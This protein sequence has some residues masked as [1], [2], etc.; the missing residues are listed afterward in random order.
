MQR[1]HGS[2]CGIHGGLLKASG[3]DDDFLEIADEP[4]MTVKIDCGSSDDTVSFSF[5]PMA[6]ICVIAGSPLRPWRPMG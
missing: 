1:G 4:H 3:A 2:Y 6:N 5:F